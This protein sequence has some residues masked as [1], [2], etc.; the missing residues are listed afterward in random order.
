MAAILAAAI[1]AG[2]ASDWRYAQ[3]LEW[4]VWNEQEKARLE[5]Q[6]FPQYNPGTDR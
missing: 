6:G 3:G 4:V 2:C 1:L 5:A